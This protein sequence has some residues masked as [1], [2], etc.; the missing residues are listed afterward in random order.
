MNKVVNNVPAVDPG[1]WTLEPGP[2]TLDP[3]TT[4]DNLPTSGSKLNPS[5][6]YLSGWLPWE[7]TVTGTRVM[8]R[9]P[10]SLSGST[11][12]FRMLVSE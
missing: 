4:T 6:R 9:S 10:P 11:T 2:W 3:P 12:S 1:T 5:E 8:T 7:H